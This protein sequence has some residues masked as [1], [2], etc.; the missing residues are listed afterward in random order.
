MR[1]MS[2]GKKKTSSAKDTKRSWPQNGAKR[3]GPFNRRW[4]QINADK[5]NAKPQSRNAGQ[6]TTLTTDHGLGEK[7]KSVQE[8]ED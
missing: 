5:G 4:T 8:I 2:I 3:A 6:G 1:R 7:L